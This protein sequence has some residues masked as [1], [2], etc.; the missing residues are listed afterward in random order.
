MFINFDTND[1]YI[2]YD[3]D[4]PW[5]Y[6]V[7]G[8]FWGNNGNVTEGFFQPEGPAGPLAIVGNATYP[9]R[10]CDDL[11]ITAQIK[12][13]LLDS[14]LPE[15]NLLNDPYVGCS[16]LEAFD[17]ATGLTFAFVITNKTIYAFYGRKIWTEDNVQVQAFMYMIP[18]VDRPS[19]TTFSTYQMVFSA[20]RGKVIFRVDG[21]DRFTITAV[22]GR[23]DSELS[24]YNNPDTSSIPLDLIFPCSVRIELGTGQFN[25]LFNTREPI[26]T[27]VF[28]YCDCQINPIE[29]DEQIC[30]N[31]VTYDPTAMNVTLLMWVNSL[32]VTRVFDI[33]PVCGCGQKPCLPPCP[34]SSS[35]SSAS[36]PFDQECT[37]SS[38]SAYNDP[39]AYYHH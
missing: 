37:S 22:G 3:D 24:A 17:D 10:H 25:V 30:H 7:V 2:G 20:K 26:C 23:L 21:D 27:D 38:Q 12:S 14:T 35:D 13:T 9:I 1:F 32:G 36:C 5:N 33:E 19:A 29:Y 28:P 8:T 15:A 18:I 34:H 11:Q 4:L 39:W 31:F 16:F 6:A